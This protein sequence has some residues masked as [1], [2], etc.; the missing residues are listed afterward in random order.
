MTLEQAR[1]IIEAFID[2]GNAIIRDSIQE[3]P[4]GW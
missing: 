1:N 4:Y 3:N 2:P